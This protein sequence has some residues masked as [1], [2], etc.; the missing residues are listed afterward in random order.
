MIM[1]DAFRHKEIFFVKI[2]LKNKYKICGHLI[3]RIEGHSRNSQ[4]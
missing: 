3:S 4:S 1:D 2:V